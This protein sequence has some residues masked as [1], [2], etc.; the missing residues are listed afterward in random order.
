MVEDN[1]IFS[2]VEK[3]DEI[4]IWDHRDAMH[5]SPQYT[6]NNMN[7]YTKKDRK[8]QRVES[9]DI[10]MKARVELKC[11]SV[12]LPIT[13][14]ILPVHLILFI[15]VYNHLWRQCALMHLPKLSLLLTI[16]FNYKW[17]IIV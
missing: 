16:K 7:L 9:K 4:V 8:E 11:D 6:R 15:L 14:Q 10:K 2:N 5:D 12:F 13:T 17:K 3:A 1:L